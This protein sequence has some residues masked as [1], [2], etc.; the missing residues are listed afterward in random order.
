[1]SVDPS[2]L[3][4]S[5][6]FRTIIGE[7][8]LRIR[9]LEDKVRDQQAEIEVLRALLLKTQSSSESHAKPFSSAKCMSCG[10]V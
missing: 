2:A 9:A 7:N 5:G 4:I 8:E 3:P 10:Y 6:Q 1:M